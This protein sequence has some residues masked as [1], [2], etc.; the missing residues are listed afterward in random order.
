M[1]TINATGVK[2]GRLGQAPHRPCFAL[3][4]IVALGFPPGCLLQAFSEC[5]QTK[6]QGGGCWMSGGVEGDLSDKF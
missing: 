4:D 1:F 6:G 3:Q 2:H 5:A